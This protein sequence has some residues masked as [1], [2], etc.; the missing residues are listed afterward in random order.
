MSQSPCFT[1]QALRAGVRLAVTG[2]LLAGAGLMARQAPPQAPSAPAQLAPAQAHRA[3]D[4]PPVDHRLDWWREARFGMFIHWGLYAVPAGEWAGRTDHGEWIR[5][6][7]KI[8]LDV[9]D[10]FRTRFNPAAFNPD[11]WVRLAKAAGMKY[12]VITTKHH[13]GFALFDSQVTDWDVLATPYGRDILKALAAAC[14]RDGIRLGF[15]YSIMDWHHPDYVPRRDWEAASRPDAGADFERYVRYMKAQLKELLTN[16]GPIGVL[17]FDGQ[18]EGTWNNERGRDLYAYVR[19]LQPDIIINN[20]V[21]RAG[22]DFGLDRDQGQLG[23]YGTPEQEIPATGLPGL[24]WETCMTMNRNWGY[25]RADKAFKP[26]RE[27]VRDLVDIASKGGNFLLNVGPTANGEFPPESVDRLNGLMRFMADAGVSVYGTQASPFPSLVWGRC[28]RKRMD[29]R[30]TRLY[31]H[32]WD[33]PAD[34]VLVVPGLLNDVKGA[35][36]LAAGALGRRLPVTRHGDDLHIALGPPVSSATSAP[37]DVVVLDIAGEPDVTVP[38][39][40]ESDAAIFVD[41][42]VVRVTSTRGGV[43]LRYTIDGSEPGPASPLVAGPIRLVRTATVKARAFRAA[44]AVSPASSAT[45][46][47]VPPQPSTPGVQAV[48]GLDYVVVEGDF[49]RL[50]DF[51]ASRPAASGHVTSL[52]LSVR[53][54]PAQFAVRFDGFLD[55]PVTGVYHL[56]LRSDDGSRLWLDGRLLVDNDGLHSAREKTADV[57]LERGLHPIGVGMFEQAGG[58]ELELSW[59]GPGIGRQRVPDAL[60]RRRVAAAGVIPLNRTR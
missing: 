32:V 4:Q 6:T 50:P 30:T 36:V 49:D 23:D 42:A 54:R 18:W 10:Q 14:R 34:N 46:T 53:T 40:I 12:I 24:D 37:E 43:D 26:T 60:L 47:R 17:W 44:R 8:P 20:R 29:D 57:A 59:S 28:T 39:A 56:H 41:A 35:S 38:P 22:G 45:F 25:N 5:N 7:A 31:L 33:R 48:P 19:S 51:S 9:Y 15:Y 21:G 16:Y 52:D 58:F 3:A 11:A 2:G 1:R 55:V 13:D 27:L